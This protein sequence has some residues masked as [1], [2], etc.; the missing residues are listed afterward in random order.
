M[1][2]RNILGSVIALV[3]ATAA[4][5]SPFRAWYDGRHGSKIRVGDLFTGI[6]AESA[7]VLGSVFLPLLVAAVGVLV[8]VVLR[9][10]ALMTGAG[11]VVLLTVVLWGVQQ[12]RAP[13]GLSSDLT[14]Y[15]L[16]FALGGAAL[17]LLG[18]AVMAGRP[19]A[20]RHRAVDG[21]RAERRTYPD[22][23]P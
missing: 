8:A 9:S 5:L 7:V 20:G 23:P 22:H 17:I 12:Y 18:A 11:L 3:G 4:V 21:D 2:I 13:A 14:G 15:G 1:M 6:T 19:G 16:G 10:R